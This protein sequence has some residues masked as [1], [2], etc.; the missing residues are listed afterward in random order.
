MGGK[1]RVHPAY[2]KQGLHLLC[3][4]HYFFRQQLRHPL[5]TY[6]RLSIA[7]LLGFVSVT[8]SLHEYILLPTTGNKLIKVI[9]GVVSNREAND[10]SNNYR[11]FC[12]YTNNL[13]P[14]LQHFCTTN[15]FDIIYSYHSNNSNN[16]NDP[17]N[18]QDKTNTDVNSNNNNNN[19][20]I[21]QVPLVNVHIQM[22]PETLSQ[23]NPEYYK[24]PAAAQFL[25]FNPV[26]KT[27]Y[28]LAS[29][30]RFDIKNIL[31]I[32]RKIWKKLYG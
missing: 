27:S 25:Q 28:N 9:N 30:F 24:R 29:A 20:G 22:T 15:H 5:T 11:E 2:R 14:I 19:E 16:Q 21:V 31:S 3:A 18:N 8:E 32:S 4:L 1:L 26:Y 17:T 13:N 6:Y 7:S 23:Y 10:T 12:E